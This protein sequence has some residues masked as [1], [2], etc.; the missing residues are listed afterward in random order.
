MECTWHE[1][2][3]GSSFGAIIIKEPRQQQR[4]GRAEIGARSSTC[5]MC[6]SE[7]DSRSEETRQSPTWYW[8][9]CNLSKRAEEGSHTAIDATQNVA[10]AGPAF[11][12]SGNHADG[13]I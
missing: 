5:G 10:C 4:L 1:V 3:F 6:F 13:D 2:K 9:V 7:C 12:H 11:F 8:F